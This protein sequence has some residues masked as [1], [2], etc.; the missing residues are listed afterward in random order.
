VTRRCCRTRNHRI[1]RILTGNIM[2]HTAV[3]TNQQSQTTKTTV[4]RRPQA[5]AAQEKSQTH[6]R[7]RAITLALAQKWPGR[8]VGGGGGGCCE[9]PG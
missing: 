3:H 6:T 5:P 8:L 1:G 9:I 7:Q 2:L 4:T